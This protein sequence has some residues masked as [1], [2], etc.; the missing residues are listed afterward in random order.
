MNGLVFL[1]PVAL[2]LGLAGLGAFFWS[3]R[4]GQYDDMDGAAMRILLDD[5]E[6]K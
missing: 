2:F 6:E 1:I 4:S 5:D 3:V